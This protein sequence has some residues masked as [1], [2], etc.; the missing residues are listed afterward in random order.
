MDQILEF[1]E[2]KSADNVSEDLHRMV[3]SIEAALLIA[4]ASG[5][6]EIVNQR[7]CDLLAVSK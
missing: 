5:Q 6:I 1:E 7:L 2:I 3:S 4:N